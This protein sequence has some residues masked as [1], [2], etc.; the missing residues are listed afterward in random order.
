MGAALKRNGAAWLVV[1][2]FAVVLAFPFYFMVIT[3]FKK[4]TDLYN[5]AKFPFWWSGGLPQTDANVAD[6]FQNTDYG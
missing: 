1:G 4:T 5:L 2:P 3:A 6:L